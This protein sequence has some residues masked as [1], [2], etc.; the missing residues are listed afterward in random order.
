MTL[1]RK[2]DLTI[3]Q[4]YVT[5]LAV[6]NGAGGATYTLEYGRVDE[7]EYLALALNLML[8]IPLLA[9]LLL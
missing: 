5:I 4:P 8:S 7:R 9:P 3:A 2:Y 6:A 1:D